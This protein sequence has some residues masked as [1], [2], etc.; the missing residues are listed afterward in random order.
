MKTAMAGEI[1]CQH[2]V[3]QTKVIVFKGSQSSRSSFSRK[4][5]SV[6]SGGGWW[7]VAGLQSAVVAVVGVRERGAIQS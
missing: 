7:R 2:S 1:S 3:L 4:S 5:K 6:R